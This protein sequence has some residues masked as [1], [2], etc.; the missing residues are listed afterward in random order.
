[1]NVQASEIHPRRRRLRLVLLVKML[2]FA[3][4]G[5]TQVA[6]TERLENHGLRV[7]PYVWATTLDADLGLGPLSLSINVDAE[8][9][10]SYLD[11]GAMGYLQWDFGNHFLFAEATLAGIDTNQFEPFFDAPVR[12]DFKLIEA[13]YGR[14]LELG[15]D[16]G[17][18]KELHLSPHIGM[19]RGS[20]EGEVSGLFLFDFDYKWTGLTIGGML[21]ARLNNKLTLT[22]RTVHSGFSGDLENY[23]NVLL[24]VR[25][26]LSD[27]IA[28]GVGY[29]IARAKYAHEDS[30]MDVNLRGALIGV[31][32]NW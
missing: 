4:L 16:L 8:D 9:A 30:L 27:R 14:L 20:L 1:M 12:A 26:S 6:A 31:E 28:M 23:L 10:F 29:R 2:I 24:A 18:I 15:R 5:S 25:Y 21:D 32:L 11:Y 19:L 22:L 13:G 3:L 17:P 7:A